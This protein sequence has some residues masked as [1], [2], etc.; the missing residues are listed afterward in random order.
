M[1]VT[2]CAGILMFIALLHRIRIEEQM[3][4]KGFGPAYTDWARKRKRLIPFIY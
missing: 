2:L 4:T 3:L 1:F